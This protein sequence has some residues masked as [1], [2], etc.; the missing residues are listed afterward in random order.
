MSDKPIHIKFRNQHNPYAGFDMIKLDELFQRQ[1]LNHSP[2]QLHLVEFYMIILVEAG[3]GFHTIDFIDYEYEKGTLLTIRK[4]QIH[5]FVKS[6]TGKGTLLLFRDDFLAS[7]LEKLEALK[8]LRLFNEFLGAPKIQLT[9]KEQNEICNSVARIETEY[10]DVNDEYSLGIIRSE[11]HILIAKLYRIKSRNNRIANNRKYLSEF[12][13]FQ[14]LVEKHATE[15]KKVKD[16]A[17]MMGISTKTINTITKTI[18]NKS[19][20]VFVDDIC[21]QQIKRLLINT[22][23]SVKEIAYSSG[24]EETTNFFKYFKRQTSLTPEQFRGNFQ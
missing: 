3:Q 15:Y 6:K 2:Y 12:I 1:G 7:Y 16:Y 9:E 23:L 19:A 22:D 4:D 20:K 24:F 18:V 5:K 17:R 21:T 8:S 10:F 11:L 13:E 14:N